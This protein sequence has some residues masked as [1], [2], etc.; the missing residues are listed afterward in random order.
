MEK[1][2][3]ELKKE[4]FFPVFIGG[5]QGKNYGVDADWKKYLDYKKGVVQPI[6]QKEILEMRILELL[7]D[8][9]FSLKELGTYLYKDVVQNVIECLQDPNM[10]IDILQQELSNRY[11]QFYFDISRNERDMGLKTFHFYIRLALS[12]QKE[13]SKSTVIKSLCSQREIPNYGMLAFYIAEHIMTLFPNN[14]L[15]EEKSVA[16][17][18]KP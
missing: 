13:T 15:K 8:Q 1:I 11:S 17:T 16:R 9:G 14:Q 4:E 18:L 12:N 5:L 10:K 7:E 3:R 2:P 6:S